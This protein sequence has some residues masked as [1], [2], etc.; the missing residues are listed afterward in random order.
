MGKAGGIPF[1][2][3]YLYGRT[4]SELQIYLVNIKCLKDSQL[5]TVRKLGLVI[6]G[7]VFFFFLHSSLESRYNFKMYLRAKEII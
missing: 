7:W 1:S 6:L 5:G 2:V 3:P 4:C